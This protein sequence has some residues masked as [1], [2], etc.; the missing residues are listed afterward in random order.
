VPAKENDLDLVSVNGTPEVLLGHI[1]LVAAPFGAKEGE[2]VTGAAKDSRLLRSVTGT[3]PR[4]REP[5]GIKEGGEMLP[6]PDPKMCLSTSDLL[7]LVAI[8]A[9][10]LLALVSGDLLSLSLLA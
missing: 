2:P 7:L 3:T 8:L 5:P 10:P 4:H 6:P 9:K 1:D